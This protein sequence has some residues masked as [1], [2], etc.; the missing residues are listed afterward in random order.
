M[1]GSAFGEAFSESRLAREQD[2]SSLA[3][4]DLKALL[5]QDAIGSRYKVTNLFSEYYPTPLQQTAKSLAAS[6]SRLPKVMKN[7]AIQ[8]DSNGYLTG[9]TTST[10]ALLD[11]PTASAS[12]SAIAPISASR[13]AL[14]PTA[15]PPAADPPA[16]PA[17]VFP[18]VAA[19]PPATVAIPGRAAPPS[20]ADT[21]LP[22]EQVALAQHSAAK[23]AD[24][25]TSADRTAQPTRATPLYEDEQPTLSPVE[26]LRRGIRDKLGYPTQPSDLAS[27]LP[28]FYLA[29]ADGPRKGE[30]LVLGRFED[31]PLDA[32]LMLPAWVDGEEGI[33]EA[34]A[35]GNLPGL[36]DRLQVQ[37][38]RLARLAQAHTS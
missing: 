25:P 30:R 21:A 17:S 9:G 18:A 15:P 8:T 2:F 28:R 34:A 3:L 31:Y 16:I 27:P 14:T 35:T 19:P 10:A 33:Y 37:S 32:H 22:V 7:A 24:S 38:V 11:A 6:S 4:L 5:G 12:T 36:R 26:W 20:A 1:W 23:R 29:Y 13:S